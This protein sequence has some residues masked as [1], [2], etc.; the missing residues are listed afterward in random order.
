[1]VYRNEGLKKNAYRFQYSL[2]PQPPHGFRAAFLDLLSPLSCSLEK[3]TR[4]SVHG[5]AKTALRTCISAIRELT[6]LRRRPQRQH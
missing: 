1:M 4:Y 3:A 6:Q 5:F 2:S